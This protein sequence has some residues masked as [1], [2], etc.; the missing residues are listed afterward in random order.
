MT[1]DF[2]SSGAKLHAEYVFVTVFIVA[3][4]G[5]VIASI[6]SISH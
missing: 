5:A 1:R 3:G 2:Y 6:A 4:G